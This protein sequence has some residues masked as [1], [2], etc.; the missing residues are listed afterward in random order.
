MPFNIG[1]TIGPYRITDQLGHGGMATVYRAYHANLDRYVA[2]KVLH[3][4]L[5]SDPNFETRFRREAQ[6]VARLDHPNIVP[7]YDY[8]EHHGEP[9]L[10]MKFI[11]GDTL[12]ARLVHKPLTLEETLHIMTAIGGALTYAHERDILHRD[13]KPSNILIDVTGVPYLAD[14]GLARMA[15]AG[16]STLSQDMML[17]T[18]QYISPEQAQ[19]VQ[20]LTASTDIYSLGVVLYELTVG[21]VPFT[22]D[23][24][25]AIIHSHIFS[26]LPLPSRVNP[27]VPAPVER[28]LMKALAKNPADRYESAVQMVDAFREAVLESGMSELSAG[29]YRVPLPTAENGAESA[30]PA[31]PPPRAPETIALPGST[32]S[33]AP[34]GP[35]KPDSLAARYARQ[36]KQRSLWILSGLATLIV[37]GVLGL[38]VVFS[39]LGDADIRAGLDVSREPTRTARTGTAAAALPGDTPTANS[40]VEATLTASASPTAG[41][42]AEAMPT[43]NAWLTVE[44]GA[45]TPDM[46]TA[47]ATVEAT[48]AG[49]PATTPTIT[50][51]DLL[52]PQQLA[53]LR[54]EEA[55]QYIIDH[56]DDP[57]GYFGMGVA[58]T[59]SG[60]SNSEALN[61]FKQAIKLAKGDPNQLLQMA[62]PLTTLARAKPAL[63][64]VEAALYAYA[65]VA[66]PNRPLI[67]NSTGLFLYG[68]ALKA[69]PG[70]GHVEVFKTV[71]ADNSSAAI[72]AFWA[73][74][75]E[76]VGQNFEA[77]QAMNKALELDSKMPEVLL[78][79]G[80]LLK[81][82]QEDAA[83]REALQAAGAV[84][85]AP[86]WVKEESR[87]LLRG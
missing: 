75:L 29:H 42:T 50:A 53:N 66:A 58:L 68:Y 47:E 87:R 49:T 65:N 33:L 55:R 63:G 37:T 81:I 62:R 73:L 84:A 80:I 79:Q 16:E 6:I 25:F 57:L 4:A 67:R 40:T 14:F 13:I 18:P 5:K 51:A 28:V 30:N 43:A 60:G 10:V 1:E 8:D 35:L 45:A 3:A 20:H 41:A 83:S 19:G 11:E 64:A 78:I 86:R 31:Q 22:A 56:P 52:S 2:I 48:S 9:Y 12:K 23:T 34:T 36:Q 71:T 39:A 82:Q 85:D 69:E 74:A 26:P 7:I 61:F 44:A 59:L 17:G 77:Q 54:P 24:P 15:S 70:N 38:F 76:K 72:Y 46:P 27:Q 21:R 32:A